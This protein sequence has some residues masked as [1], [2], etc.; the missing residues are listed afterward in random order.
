MNFSIK[1]MSTEL[2]NFL[3]RK[4]YLSITFL[5]TSIYIQVNACWAIRAPP[6]PP[7]EFFRLLNSPLR[8]INFLKAPTGGV[9][10]TPPA[11][12]F[13]KIIG[14]HGELSGRKNSKRQR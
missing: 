13:K 7:L 8:P 2:S 1:F 11:G 10:G 3:Q 6:L 14:P 5:Y 12:A 9:P 4:Y